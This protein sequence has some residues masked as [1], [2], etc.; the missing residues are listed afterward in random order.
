MIPLAVP[1]MLMRRPPWDLD[2]QLKMKA[3]LPSRRQK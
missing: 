1:A 3:Y 2:M